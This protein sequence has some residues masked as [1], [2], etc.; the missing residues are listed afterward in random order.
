M[1]RI[2]EI[3]DPENLLNPGVILNPDPRAHVNNLK[4][5]PPAHDLIDKCIECGFCE[6]HCPSKNLSLTP[7]QRIVAFREMA[8]LRHSRD[9]A[10][11]LAQF[12][13][14]FEYLGDE[15]CATDGL[16]ATSCPVGI[17]T[18]KLIKD[19]RLVHHGPT[20]HSIAEIVADNMAI[21]TG[22][23]RLA[24][25]V[26]SALHGIVGRAS[27]RAQA[28]SCG[29]FRATE[30]LFGILI[31]REEPTRSRGMGHPT[32]RPTVVYFPT[33]IN[34]S[35]GGTRDDPDRVR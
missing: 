8:R 31:C 6:V 29:Q 35:M 17:D 25:N 34:R 27:C 22:G 5:L 30:F 14:Q 15:T 32:M 12:Q 3:F 7:R 21:V 20:A 19:L 33:C 23:I 9:D 4:P 18:G 11:R 13:N 28:D 2:K 1:K 26:V 24:L 10:G 16:C